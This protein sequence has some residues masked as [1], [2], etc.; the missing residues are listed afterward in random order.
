M[1][2]V[3][4]GYGNM[5]SAERIITIVSPESAPIK[6]LVQ[7]ARDDGRAIDATYGRKTRTV[8]VST[9]ILSEVETLCSRAIIISGGKLVADSSIEELK[10]RFGHELSVKVSVAGYFDVISSKLKEIHS[11][12][13]VTRLGCETINAG[14]PEEIVLNTILISVAGNEE[15]RPA[16]A[17]ACVENGFDLYEMSV[18]KNSLE[19]VFH[20]LTEKSEK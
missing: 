1:K 10:E 16:V 12:A 14:T 8:I 9:H 3:N 7:E 19:D 13:N 18:Q 5:V 6:R 4:I 11:I 15:I 17:K 20:A 2:L